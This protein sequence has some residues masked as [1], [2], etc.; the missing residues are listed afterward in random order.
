M[1]GRYVLRVILKNLR[2]DFDLGFDVRE[3]DFPM[4][5]R[6]RYNIAPTQMVSVIR[7]VD[8]IRRHSLLR[9]GFIPYWSKGES[10]PQINARGETAFDK[11]MFRDAA[12][13]RR[14]LILADGFYEWKRD[15]RE[16]AIQAYFVDRADGKPF[17]MAGIWD[18]WVSGD[19]EII[20][21]VAIVTTD[22]NAEVA[23]IHDRMPVILDRRDYL[24]WL[25]ADRVAPEDARALIRPPPDGT[26]VARPVDNRVNAVKNDDADNLKPFDPAQAPPQPRK[27]SDPRQGDLF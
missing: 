21:T 27:G 10:R 25:E 24:T 16:R 15:E 11:P 4:Q 19:G 1:C 13:A 22:A 9:W 2:R 12:R 7:V 18:A 17:A 14:C 26:M 6:P 23:A 3:S 20:E 5:D 8:G